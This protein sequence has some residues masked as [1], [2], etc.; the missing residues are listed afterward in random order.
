MQIPPTGVR[1]QLVP[2]SQEQWHR[3]F[4]SSPCPWILL[5][6][7]SPLPLGRVLPDWPFK[8]IHRGFFCKS[9][10]S[11]KEALTLECTVNRQTSC[12]CTPLQKKTVQIFHCF[13]Y[14]QYLICKVTKT[15]LEL[16]LEMCF[17]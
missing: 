3:G 17:S 15:R 2:L 8:N 11:I 9:E 14:T 16:I 13:V 7:E 1:T 12:G 6:P 4:L 10:N 5:D